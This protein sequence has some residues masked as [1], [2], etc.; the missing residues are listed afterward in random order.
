MADSALLAFVDELAMEG[1][2]SATLVNVR[3]MLQRL[4]TGGL[5]AP[6]LLQQV[7]LCSET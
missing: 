7:T 5:K 6:A 4:S 2:G 1:S 3:Q